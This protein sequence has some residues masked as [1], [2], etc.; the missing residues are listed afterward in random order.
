MSG[1]GYEPTPPFRLC[2]N[3]DCSNQPSVIAVIEHVPILTKILTVRIR[4]SKENEMERQ[5]TLVT[6]FKYDGYSKCDSYP[7]IALKSEAIHNSILV[8]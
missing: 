3:G 7:T 6:Q 5:P 2:E 1:V 4:R 8:E